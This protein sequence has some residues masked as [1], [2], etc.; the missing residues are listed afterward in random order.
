MMMVD[1]LFEIPKWKSDRQQEV[2]D[3]YL[4]QGID[5]EPIFYTALEKTLQD[6]T[7]PSHRWRGFMSAAMNGNIIG[8]IKGLYPDRMQVDS[9]GRDYFLLDKQTRIYLKKLDNRY[10]PRNIPTNHVRELNSMELLLK[11]DPITVLYAGFRLKE[12]EIWDGLRGCYLVEMKGLRKTNWISDLADLGAQMA[13]PMQPVIPITPLLPG[14]LSGDITVT[15]KANKE[16][17]R[18]AEDAGQ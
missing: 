14:D 3:R 2:E 1:A 8:T 16:G 17:G 13:P 18:T 6:P 10:C 9:T 4:T 7:P 5:F 15:V 12:D 11:D